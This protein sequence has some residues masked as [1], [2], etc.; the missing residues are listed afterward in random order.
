[1]GEDLTEESFTNLAESLRESMKRQPVFFLHPTQMEQT[2]GTPE[3]WEEA[4]RRYCA[5]AA[6]NP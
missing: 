2:Q 3:Q 1:M 4:M 5:E 6:K